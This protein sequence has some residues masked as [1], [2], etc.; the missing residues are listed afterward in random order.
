MTKERITV[1]DVPPPPAQ[2]RL[3]KRQQWALL[4]R[5]IRADRAM[6]VRALIT[7]VLV[8]PLLIM[9]LG[10]AALLV[11]LVVLIFLALMAGLLSA[12]GVQ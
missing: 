3:T 6:A 2:S 12:L 10:V 11:A 1:F 5:I 8:A 7:L 4:Y 9:L